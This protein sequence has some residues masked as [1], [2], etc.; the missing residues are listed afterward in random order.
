MNAG[1]CKSV[2][3]RFGRSVKALLIPSAKFPA[4]EI[5]YP[6]SLR[7]KA[8]S[9]DK[10]E[11]SSTISIFCAI[12]RPFHRAIPLPRIF[13]K[14]R[15]PSALT[16]SSRSFPGLTLRHG[17]TQI[18]ELN[19][20]VTICQFG[21]THCQ[22]VK[23]YAANALDFLVFRRGVRFALWHWPRGRD[24]EDRKESDT[25]TQVDGIAQ[26][27]HPYSSRNHRFRRRRRLSSVGRDN[28][29]DR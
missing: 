7:K 1:R 29:R 17:L 18:V 12:E 10:S 20:L 4:R 27:P 6:A 11:L 22:A 14:N 9:C 3:M 28:P 21:A 5:S 26:G 16:V 23:E 2:I 19:R 8:R 15:R 24:N 25:A 13:S